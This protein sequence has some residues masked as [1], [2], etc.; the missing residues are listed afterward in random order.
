MKALIAQD[1]MLQYPDHNK[2]FDIYTGASDYQLGA[3]IVQEGVPVTCFSRKLT[4]TQK[5]YTTLEKELLSIFTV[6]KSFDTMLF[7]AQITIH[8]YHKNL[9]YTSTVNNCILHQLNYVERFGPTYKHI[10]GD[11]NFL[12]DMFSQLDRLDEEYSTSQDTPLKRESINNFSFILDDEELL[13]CFLNLPDAI[14]L[15]FALDLEQI[16][17]G[18][19]NDPA[20]WQRRLAHPLTTLES[21]HSNQHQ[22]LHGRF[23]S[24][25]SN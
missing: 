7:G 21:S 3:V 8:T 23:A 25:L 2:P 1:C 22:M 10:A 12:A 11:D 19:Q 18:Q 17:Q 5:K 4:K 15:P 13:E 24:Q 9:T 16:A 20:L 6:F 14:D